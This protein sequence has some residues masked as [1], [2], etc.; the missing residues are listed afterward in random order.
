MPA[1]GARKPIH[2]TVDPVKVKAARAPSPR[3]NEATLPLQARLR[4][5]DHQFGGC[6]FVPLPGVYV[7]DNSVFSMRVA[8]CEITTVTVA[9]VLR[10]PARSR[11]AALSVCMPLVTVVVSSARAKGAVVTSAPSGAPSIRNRTPATPMLS[12]LSALMVTVPA[13]RPPS[14]GAGRAMGGGG[15]STTSPTALLVTVLSAGSRAT[16]GTGLG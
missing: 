5:P 15:L 1:Q 11:A 9:E 7:M 8:A 4:L 14:A 6:P 10:L 2:R 13:M 3:V 12:E 16:P